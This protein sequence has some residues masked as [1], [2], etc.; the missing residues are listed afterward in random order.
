MSRSYLIERRDPCAP[1][2]KLGSML[3]QVR[4]HDV[5]GAISLEAGRESHQIII[6][7]GSICE[8]RGPG[9]M[10]KDERA[11]DVFAL[12]RP[13]VTF[14]PHVLALSSRRILDPVHLLISG[15]TRS[16]DLFDPVLFKD[17]VPVTALN[18]EYGQLLALRKLPFL[19]EEKAFFS[20][21]L[22]PTPV[23]MILWKRGL[24]PSHAAALLTTLNL[25]GVWATDWRPGHLPRIHPAQRILKQ[26][27]TII[28]DYQ[29]LGL[30][31]DASPADV[32]KAFRRISFE[33]HPDRNQGQSLEIRS[34]CDTAFG[35]VS[36]AYQRLKQQRTSR[37][38]RPV[39]HRAAD[40]RLWQD[41][42]TAAETALIQGQVQLA[43][44]HAIRGLLLN[45]PDFAKARFQTLLQ[46]AA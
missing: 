42:L 28:D 7:K 5:N 40:T 24:C 41:A 8:V 11:T 20:R 3:T 31:K 15:M 37:R 39:V 17:R 32:D 22:H 35:A 46:Q 21:L 23:P 18:I 33:L 9:G 19:E 6:A 14:A 16:Q 30:P 27:A 34:V 25:L 38:K 12:N 13:L 4:H 29:L 43:R 10:V 1:V 26:L 45:P 44:K 2:L 36:A